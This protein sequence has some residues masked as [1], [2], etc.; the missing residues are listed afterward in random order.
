MGKDPWPRI[1]SIS[2]LSELW[3]WWI[4]SSCSKCGSDPNLSGNGPKQFSRGGVSSMTTVWCW[5]GPSFHSL[6]WVQAAFSPLQEAE[7][8]RSPVPQADKESSVIHHPWQ[9]SI[10]KTLTSVLWIWEFPKE[11]LYCL[12]T[13]V[14]HQSA[15][16][17]IFDKNGSWAEAFDFR[18]FSVL[19]LR[20][21]GLSCPTRIRR[22]WD[23]NSKIFFQCVFL[24]PERSPGQSGSPASGISEEL[25]STFTMTLT[26]V[27][28]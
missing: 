19:V 5:A 18:S 10:N 17:G 1:S 9:L 26:F 13:G 6:V 23:S 15:V 4:H 8:A 22:C 21:C 11:P 28:S 12:G 7:L 20:G 2:I 3:L 27:L 16:C 24:S 25:F 14:H